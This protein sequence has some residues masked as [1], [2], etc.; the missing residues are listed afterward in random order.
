[1]STENEFIEIKINQKMKEVAKIWEE[2]IPE[3]IENSV[4][5]GDGR[6]VGCLGETFY[7]KQ[8]KANRVG[9][10]NFDIIMNEHTYEVKSKH[11]NTSP[12]RNYDCTVFAANI[13][14]KADYYTFTRI[15]TNYSKG[16]IL[17]YIPKE[18]FLRIAEF[19]PKGTKL[20]GSNRESRAD[21]YHVLIS[22]LTPFPKPGILTF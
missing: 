18:K 15:L 19:V 10:K 2:E 7:V 20:K 12:L 11:C 14:Q 4:M 22:D 8:F 1:M 5:D 21:A 6:F 3:D 13:N 16:W 17:G 9:T